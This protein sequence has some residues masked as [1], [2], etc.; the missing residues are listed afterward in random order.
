M[1]VLALEFSSPRRA[2]SIVEIAPKG[3]TILGQAADHDY[4]T[5]PGLALV[6][7]ALELAKITPSE[8]DLIAVGRGP[9]S[10]TGIRSSI[11]IA[12]GWQLGRNTPLIGISSVELLAAQ[13]VAANLPGNVQIIIDAQRS[14]LYSAVYGCSTGSPQIV[15]PLEIIPK[16]A[17]NPEAGLNIIGPEAPRFC[18][19]A[20]EW[21]PSAQTLA[22]LA[23]TRTEYI[24]GESLEPIYL[25]PA[26]FV[27][28]PPP[29][30]I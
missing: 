24:P 20:Q 9:G 27:K 6:Q 10:Y 28:A 7:Q 2:V 14:E 12:Q 15:R 11:A 29:R 30:Q 26:A 16:A 25:R 21:F 22:T 13:Y 3:S 17:L 1:K 23:A 18:P 4:R 5:R 8:I 19:A